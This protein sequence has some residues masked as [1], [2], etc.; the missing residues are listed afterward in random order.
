MTTDPLTG[1]LT[2]ES[3]LQELRGRRAG[4]VVYIDIVGLVFSN[5]VLGPNATDQLLVETGN[6]LV[7]HCPKGLVARAVS[8]EFVA[9][10]EKMENATLLAEIFATA[11][12]RQLAQRRARVL[13]GTSEAGVIHAPARVLTLSM[14]TAAL[15]NHESLEAALQAADSSRCPRETAR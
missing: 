2:L 14:G 5:F 1:L 4:G 8:D 6:L 12:D 10:T 7:A 15:E 3:F 13:T 9:F 11:F